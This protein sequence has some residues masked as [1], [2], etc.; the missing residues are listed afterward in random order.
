MASITC[1]E[2]IISYRITPQVNLNDLRETTGASSSVHQPTP[3]PS[4]VTSRPSS[5]RAQTSATQP[6]ASTKPAPESTS[7]YLWNEAYNELKQKEPKLL[8]TY[9]KIISQKLDND[10]FKPELKREKNLVE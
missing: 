6:H 7:E 5:S 9:E 10:D 3:P 1:D 8:E 2:L 4:T